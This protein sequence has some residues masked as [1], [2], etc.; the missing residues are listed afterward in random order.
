MSVDTNPKPYNGIL[1]DDSD[2]TWGYLTFV[3]DRAGNPGKELYVALDARR[4]AIEERKP[5]T[6]VK[7]EPWSKI[8]DF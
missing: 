6:Y 1:K 2:F 5:G 8:F 7:R 3:I 4:K